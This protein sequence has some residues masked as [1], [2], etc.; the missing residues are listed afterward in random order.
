MEHP[1][2]VDPRKNFGQPTIVTDGI[3][4]Q[5]LARSFKANGSFEEVARWYEI[6]PKSVQEAVDY[7]HSLA[8]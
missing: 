2:V 6:S 4:T 3:P 8:A 1:V 5:T 7:E